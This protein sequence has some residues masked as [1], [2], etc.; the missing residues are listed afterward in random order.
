MSHQGSLPANWIWSQ[1]QQLTRA[2]FKDRSG[3]TAAEHNQ[4]SASA[5]LHP[6]QT[7]NGHHASREQ[8]HPT[9]HAIMI[10][11]ILCP[12]PREPPTGIG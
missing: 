10:G 2:L 1:P 3:A 9:K 7:P 4:A 8:G 11:S 6:H 12:L 5:S